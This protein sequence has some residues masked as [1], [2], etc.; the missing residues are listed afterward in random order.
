MS[1]RSSE[2]PCRPT[3]ER[4]GPFFV[5]G[6]P[7]S[8]TTLLTMLLNAHS[9]IA[10]AP[11]THYFNRLWKKCSPR[12]MRSKRGVGRYLDLVFGS[13]LPRDLGLGADELATIREDIESTDPP[14]HR[15][16]LDALL[17]S[18]ARAR[19]ADIWGEKTPLHVN[20][21][22][23]I[24]AEFPDAPIIH[25]IRDPRDIL[26]SLQSVPWARRGRLYYV[27]WWR[28]CAR[29]ADHVIQPPVGGY[30]E[31]RYEDLLS[32]PEA[33]VRA[34]CRIV[35]VDFEST[36]LEYHTRS[37]RPSDVASEFWKSKNLDPID[38]GNTGK[39]K[40][41][42]TTAE[43]GM[44]ELVAGRQMR[45]KGYDTSRARCAASMG[46]LAYCVVEYVFAGLRHY[47][48]RGWSRLALG[49]QA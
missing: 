23:A 3:E 49:R 21:V 38:P 14:S 17:S 32:R 40:S 9:R 16:I 8:G 39:W 47:L 43:A 12:C 41:R 15:V 10:V 19:D 37:E 25:V 28:R 33:T 6:V 34:M 36:M 13:M 45:S 20:Y 26:A 22:S 31:V 30:L 1:A 48:Q 24:R 5:V 27:A 4:P 42:L 2:D 7:R 46:L 29:I 11:E 18:Y 44:V 35:G